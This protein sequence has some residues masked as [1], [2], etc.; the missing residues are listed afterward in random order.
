M[1][2]GLATSGPAPQDFLVAGRRR[3]HA[4]DPRTGVPVGTQASISVLAPDAVT[5]DVAPTVLGLLPSGGAAAEAPTLGVECLVVAS[6]R[7]LSTSAGRP[8]AGR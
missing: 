4:I 1:N 6:D 3:S 5:A 2:G 8:V 7:G